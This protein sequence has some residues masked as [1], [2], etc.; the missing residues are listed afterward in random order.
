MIKTIFHRVF[1]LS[2]SVLLLASCSSGN[3]SS[4]SQKFKLRDGADSL[5]YVIG[6]NIA[7]NVIKL[8]STLNADA[9]CLGIAER[10][11]G[12]EIFTTEE[13][14]TYYLR[15]MTHVIPE[16]RRSYENKF[17][18]E[19]VESDRNFTRYDDDGIAYHVDVIGD[20]SFTPRGDNDLVTFRYT[21]ARI[22]GTQLY[23]SYEKGDTLS[24]G[25]GSLTKGVQESL[26]LIGKGGKIDV[27]MPSS[28]AYGN[29][30]DEELGVEPYE[31][32]YFEIEL[33]DTERN[34]ASKA[35]KIDADDF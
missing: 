32:L 28:F 3:G 8:D 18:A 23:S 27:W 20:E 5:A 11:R 26:K 30:G 2:L 35:N 12:E 6:M 13:A 7:D 21:I 17:L 10:M 15:Y 33:I 25:L 29:D 22:D 14:R 24:Q 34:A 9:I 1:P 31:T 4:K 16:I 19:L